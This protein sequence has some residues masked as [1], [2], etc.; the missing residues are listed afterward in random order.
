[1]TTFLLLEAFHVSTTCG[2]CARTTDGLL[3]VV[4]SDLADQIAEC[5][6]D[7]DALLGRGFDEAARKVLR[8]LAALCEERTGTESAFGGG[9]GLCHCHPKQSARAALSRNLI[10]H[11]LASA[12]HA[13]ARTQPSHATHSSIHPQMLPFCSV[14]PKHAALSNSP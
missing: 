2:R 3:L 14:A 4:S 6:V 7:V 13:A 8:K 12:A 5:F 1:M 11:I 10:A 9:L